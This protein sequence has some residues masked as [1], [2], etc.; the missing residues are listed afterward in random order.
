MGLTA[1]TLKN[2]SGVII[3]NKLITFTDLVSGTTSTATTD[4]SGLYSKFLF[5]PRQ[6]RATV[7]NVTCTPDPMNVLAGSATINLVKP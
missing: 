5:G 4:G 2:G 6:Y 1:G 7:D 3:P